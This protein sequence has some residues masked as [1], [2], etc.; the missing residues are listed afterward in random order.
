VFS[1]NSIGPAEQFKST[2]REAQSVP[3]DH[4]LLDGGLARGRECRRKWA[5]ARNPYQCVCQYMSIDNIANLS[6][7]VRVKPSKSSQ[8]QIRVSAKEKAAIRRA[9]RR[10]GLDM[11]QYVLSRVLP[12]LGETFQSLVRRVRAADTSGFVLAELHAFL[13]A[14]TPAEL[15]EA[16]AAPP[17]PALPPFLANY[18][19]AMVETA[20]VRKSER[21]PE[22]TQRIAP[23]SE[24]VFG[25][26]LQS[27]RMYL[28]THS[29]PA[30]RRRNIF[31]DSTLGAQV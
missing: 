9:A 3:V 10:S 27:L 12:Q 23:L 2:A 8:L 1:R 30:F 31:I 5:R 20:S 17:D 29:P 21:V 28:L 25:S 26:A 13:E 6:H 24:P 4:D 19:A 14:L 15:S 18:V 7:A 16:A 11:S 22:W